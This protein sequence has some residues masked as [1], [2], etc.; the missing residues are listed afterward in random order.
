[1]EN[2][3]MSKDSNTIDGL[4]ELIWSQLREDRK[5]ILDQYQEIRGMATR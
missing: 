1:M 4:S 2:F 3:K 5:L